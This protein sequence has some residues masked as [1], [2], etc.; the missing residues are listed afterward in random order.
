VSSMK[1]VYQAE[2]LS[3]FL[4]SSLACGQEPTKPTSQ[5]VPAPLE[6][7]L[8]K[9]PLW[10]G[11][12]LELS[13]QR[14]NLSKFSIFLDAAY[15]GIKVY[16][17][18]SDA[19]STLGQGPGEAWML[20]YGWT[21]VISEPIKL[22]PGTRRQNTLCVA[23]TFPVKETGK[24]ILRQVRVQGKLRIVAGY[25]IPTWRII[26]QP[27]GKGR[28]TY[29][30]MADNPNHWAFGEVVLEIPIPCPDG[31][32][33]SDCLAPPQIF[34]GEHDVHTFKL[35]PPPVIET[36]PPPLPMLPID[37]PPPPKP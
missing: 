29:V 26:D 9:G 18:V 19:T 12:C 15:A 31:T 17:S 5:S 14:R 34:P 20:V 11:N 2:L 3:I 27:Q 24:E 35:E 23:E 8:T 33:T 36:Q 37:S 16:S 13:V 22:V 7:K 32:G 6:L 4:V 10:K 1:F 30:R 28:R 21:D 25:E